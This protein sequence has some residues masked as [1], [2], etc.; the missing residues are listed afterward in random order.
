MNLMSSEGAFIPPSS[1]PPRILLTSKEVA[2]VLRVTP[3]TIRRWTHDG[4]LEPVRVGG[5]IVRY[6]PESV[7]ALI[8]PENESSSPAR[9]SLTKAEAPAHG[10]L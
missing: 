9:A 7:E 3:R 5:R 6:T 8:H 10:A 1:S 4:I 2:A